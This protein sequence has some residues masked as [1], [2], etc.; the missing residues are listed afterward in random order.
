M[1]GKR[2]DPTPADDAQAQED[3]AEAPASQEPTAPPRTPNVPT[4]GVPVAPA[5][6]PESPADTGTAPQVNTTGT[7]AQENTDPQPK[8]PRPAWADAPPAY[9]AVQNPD[10]EPKGNGAALWEGDTH[11]IQAEPI[12]YVEAM[13]TPAMRGEVSA[14]FLPPGVSIVEH[15]QNVAEVLAKQ[16][17]EVSEGGNA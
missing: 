3:K 15:A 6:S 17:A 4:T 5:A 11:P 1:P 2:T 14:P 10:P 7:A 16:A 13:S 8:M 12:P 9:N